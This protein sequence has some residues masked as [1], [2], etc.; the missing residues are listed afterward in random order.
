LMREPGTVFRS[1]F[2]RSAAES[3]RMFEDAVSL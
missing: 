3:S 2:H 1:L